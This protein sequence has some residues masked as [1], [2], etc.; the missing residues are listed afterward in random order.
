MEQA[1]KEGLP[2]SSI[3]SDIHSYS[4]MGP[5]FDLPTTMSKMLLL[6]LPLQKVIELATI[7]PARAIRRERHLGSI[8]PGRIADI[9]VFDLVKGKFPLIDSSREVRE[10]SEKLIPVLA[11]RDGKLTPGA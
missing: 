11:L 3:S 10:A 5:V 7:E 2:P 4:A 6:G 1:L 9:A 8:A